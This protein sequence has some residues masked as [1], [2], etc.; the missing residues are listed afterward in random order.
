[1]D[2]YHDNHIEAGRPD[3]GPG[4]R[5]VTR[6]RALQVGG[7]AVGLLAASGVSARA[8]D[9]SP[10]GEAGPPAAAVGFWTGEDVSTP[11][12]QQPNSPTTF[13]DPSYRGALTP[14]VWRVL[15]EDRVPLYLNLR[16]GRD[17][18]PVPAGV[19]SD[20]APLVRMANAHGVPVVTWLVVPYGQGYWAYEGNAQVMFDA[21][22]A[23]ASWASAQRLR[24]ESVALDQEFSYQNL[25][26]YVTALT[27]GDPSAIATW[28]SGNIDPAGQRTALKTYQK[29]LS[30]AHARGIRV[31][32]AEVPMV[33]DDLADGYLALQDALDIAGSLPD[34]DQ[35][36]LMAYRS[37]VAEAGTDPGSAYVASY[38]A[39]MQKYFGTAGQVSLGIG[40]QSPY[41]TLTP[42]VNDIRM[43]AGL[44]ATQI[45]VYSLETTVAAFGADG[46]KT[47]VEA[48]RQPM[49]GAELATASAPTPVSKAIR[50]QG[51]AMDATAVA[52]TKTVTTQ[53]G[54]PQAPN[55]WP[56]R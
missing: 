16:Y 15:R 43:L 36:Y 10:F 2:R 41:D 42:L 52:L 55:A 47:I 53:Q 5:V 17:F 11:Q 6:R 27:S 48:A 56:I 50:A 49:R 39:D 32:A 14:A 26:A 18:G 25:Q 54:H 33:A 31:T 34:Y 24:F 19:T 44:G 35:T 28:M 46:L 1:M 3:S 7:L 38:Y 22:R 29:I 37:A 40:G 9:A 30:W 12:G 21:V 23:W 4:A 51:Y 13:Y 45:P 20:A 8:A